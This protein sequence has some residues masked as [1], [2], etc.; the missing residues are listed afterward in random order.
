MRELEVF[1]AIALCMLFFSTLS[2]L[3]TEFLHRICMLRSRQ[4]DTMLSDW[5][6]QEIKGHLAPL[7]RR[8]SERAKRDFLKSLIAVKDPGNRVE[9]HLLITKLA[10]SELGQAIYAEANTHIR[11]VV[12]DIAR[13]YDNIANQ[14][15]H[16]FRAKA[17]MIS[18]M[19]SVLMALALNVNLVVLAKTFL[20]NDSLTQGVNEQAEAIMA[21]AQAQIDDFADLLQQ[22]ERVQRQQSL[23][24][25]SA[26]TPTPTAIAAM[27]MA[28]DAMTQLESKLTDIG[29]QF[30]RANDL[31]LPIL[32]HS[33]YICVFTLAAV[34]E[35]P[36]TP[37]NTYR[38]SVIAWVLW[39][40]STVITGLLIGLGAPF[41]FDFLK[42][43]AMVTRLSP[44][45]PPNEHKAT[46]SAD[47]DITIRAMNNDEY[48]RLFAD[49]IRVQQVI[50]QQRSESA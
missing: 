48:N 25:G 32:K 44:M 40:L 11:V 41:W 5:F 46:A 47:P 49:T 31:D 26:A 20:Q 37:N 29:A 42:K 28:T 7:L 17:R 16:K 50:K 8:V 15:V 3:A 22:L 27:P 34:N 19:V 23:E 30:N 39:F 6:E 18:L 45:A 12:N 35:C 21:S 36:D 9:T 43:F 24:A 10:E 1:F 13:R 33:K 14:T 38:G 4:L 2:S